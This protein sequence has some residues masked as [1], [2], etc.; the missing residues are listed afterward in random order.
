MRDRR[1]ATA[2]C[3][4][5]WPRGSASAA[6]SSNSTPGATG[7]AGDRAARAARAPREPAR[8]DVAA[9][10]AAARPAARGP[11][12]DRR[13]TAR[14]SSAPAARPSAARR[15]RA[16]GSAAAAGRSA[17]RHGAAGGGCSRRARA[18]S[19]AVDGDGVR[20]PDPRAGAAGGTAAGGWP[21]RSPRRRR[22]L[23]LQPRPP[24]LR[25][26][27][28]ATAGDVLVGLRDDADER[29][30][31][32]RAARRA[33]R[34]LRRTPAPN[35]SISTSAL[36]VST[37]ARMSPPW[38]RSPSFLSHLMILPLSIASESLGMSTLVTAMSAA[39]GRR[40]RSR[41]L[42]TLR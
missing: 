38:M 12:A 9:H 28:S 13:P 24:A 2:A 32:H 16:R 11:A 7:T 36:S 27:G 3:A 22:A 39:P 14:R 10:D 19:A 26:P 6:R 23:R 21:S 5:R 29:A 25:P 8:L 37:S 4:W 40:W 31:G 41:R 17:R 1:L 20:P 30:D 15:R 35:A 18:R 34:I 42:R 33:S